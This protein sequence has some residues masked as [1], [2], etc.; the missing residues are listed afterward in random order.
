MKGQSNRLLERHEA[1]QHLDCDSDQQALP[2]DGKM[3]RYQRGLHAECW[4]HRRQAAVL[5]VRWEEY[6]IAAPAPAPARLQA[7]ALNAHN[8]VLIHWKIAAQSFWWAMETREL[9]CP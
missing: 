8:Q 7:V 5:K 3:A 4:A 9:Q 2:M 1:Q 6:S